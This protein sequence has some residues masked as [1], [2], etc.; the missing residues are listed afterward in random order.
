MVINKFVGCK[1]AS[2]VLVNL[3]NINSPRQLTVSITTLKPNR[4]IE[5]DSKNDDL[6][7]YTRRQNLRIS[8]IPGNV[9]GNTDDFVKIFMPSRNK[10]KMI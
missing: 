2:N 7:Q 1:C 3:L 9:G 4:G 5:L 10:S 8:G 6:E